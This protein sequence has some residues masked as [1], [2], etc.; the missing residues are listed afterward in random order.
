MAIFPNYKEIGDTMR[1]IC[2]SIFT[3]ILA[4][5]VSSCDLIDLF[6]KDKIEPPNWIIGEWE[7]VGL[8]WNIH[9]LPNNVIIVKSSTESPIITPQDIGKLPFNDFFDSDIEYRIESK[10]GASSYVYTKY[11]FKKIDEN[12]LLFSYEV[13]ISSDDN[14]ELFRKE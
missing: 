5:T 3:I 6:I 7:N 11:L 13:G 12:K 8:N 9:F 2:L 14:I 10:K 4:T 1:K